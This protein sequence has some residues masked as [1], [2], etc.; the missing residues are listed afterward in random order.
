M[1]RHYPC[2]LEKQTTSAPPATLQAMTP[3]PNGT[4]GRG[5]GGRFGPG[6]RFGHGNPLGGRVARL[7][8]AL[9]GAVTEDDM[10]HLARSLV[11][12]AKEGDAAA[13]KLVLAYCVGRPEDDSESSSQPGDLLGLK[14][15]VMLQSCS[16]QELQEAELSGGLPRRLFLRH[17]DD[18]DAVDGVFGL[19][20]AGGAATARLLG[21][22]E[23]GGQAAPP[24][25]IDVDPDIAPLEP[26]PKGEKP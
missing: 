24:T 26:N 14:I 1:W 13:A 7:R 21:A 17:R 16:M 25:I 11:D 20:G 19:P 2:V 18:E 8:S 9:L 12:R 4:N 6:N 5:P 15:G 22:G 23:N 3:S 10:R